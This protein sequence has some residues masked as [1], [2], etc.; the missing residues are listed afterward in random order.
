MKTDQNVLQ[1]AIIL[2][3]HFCI[4]LPC[5]KMYFYILHHNRRAWSACPV[6]LSV[7]QSNPPIYCLNVT[8]ITGTNLLP[9]YV[10]GVKTRL[11]FC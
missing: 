7:R 6:R 1:I 2:K 9:C 5:V 8:P 3:V 4:W 10:K 11:L